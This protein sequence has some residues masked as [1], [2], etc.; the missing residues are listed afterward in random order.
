MLAKKTLSIKVDVICIFTKTNFTA[1]GFVLGM[2]SIYYPNDSKFVKTRVSK[3][4]K[5]VK[6]LASTVSSIF[7]TKN[8]ILKY[9]AVCLQQIH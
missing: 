8:F 7:L 1:A 4:L 5:T 9:D 3:S 6:H 2:N